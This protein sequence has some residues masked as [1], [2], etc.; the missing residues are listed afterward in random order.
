MFHSPCKNIKNKDC[1]INFQ[2][3]VRLLGNEDFLKFGMI[4]NDKF[5]MFKKLP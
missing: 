1:F 5:G 3:V 2:K 4:I